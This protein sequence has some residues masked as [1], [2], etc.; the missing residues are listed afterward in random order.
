MLVLACVRHDGRR[1]PTRNTTRQMSVFDVGLCVSGADNVCRL[2]T[3]T[4][5]GSSCQI[6]S[7]VIVGSRDMGQHKRLTV[8]MV[9]LADRSPTRHCRL[10]CV[11][12]FTSNF[13]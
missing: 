9:V 8:L 2:V 7:D 1:E 11:P 5:F 6:I 3:G 12:T 10:S 4:S 13:S